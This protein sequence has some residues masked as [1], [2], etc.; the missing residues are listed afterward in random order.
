MKKTML[1]LSIL[2]VCSTCTKEDCDEITYYE[3]INCEGYVFYQYLDGTLTPYANQKVVIKAAQDFYPGMSG[4][5][6]AVV[7]DTVQ[8]DKNGFY[9]GVRFVKSIRLA[10]FTN[11][12][13]MVGYHFLFFDE[14][15]SSG[16]QYEIL[17]NILPV[18][19]VKQAEKIATRQ[20]P[21]TIVRDTIFLRQRK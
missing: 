17:N 3:H 14:N 5:S 9:E 11:S 20:N 16:S 13:E 1:L 12:Y 8:T 6:Y 18:E 7:R 10:K 21:Q 15:T 4:P 2:F 19:V